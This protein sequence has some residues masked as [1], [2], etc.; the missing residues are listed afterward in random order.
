MIRNN[1]LAFALVGAFAL[2]GTGPL[3]GGHGEARVT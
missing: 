2:G 3:G 1:R